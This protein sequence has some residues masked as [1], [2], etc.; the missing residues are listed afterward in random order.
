MVL[1]HKDTGNSCKK[2]PNGWPD[3]LKILFIVYFLLVVWH[4]NK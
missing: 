3:V 1:L 2:A 4:N